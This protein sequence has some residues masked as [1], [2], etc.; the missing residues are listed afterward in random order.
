MFPCTNCGCCC[1]RVGI[2]KAFLT[3]DEFPFDVDENG[4]CK[5]LVNNMCSVY[6]NRPDI[7]KVE[8]MSKKN[9]IPKEIY[10]KMAIDVCNRM[11]DED[12]I[13]LKFRIDGI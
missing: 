12:N 8:E 2:I 5:M 1:K 3:D 6:D 4:S 9:N 13:P 11:M 7:C 10:Y